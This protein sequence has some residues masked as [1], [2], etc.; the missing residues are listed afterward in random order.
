MFP[1]LFQKQQTQY[2]QNHRDQNLQKP[3]AQHKRKQKP[4]AKSNEQKPCLLCFHTHKKSPRSAYAGS[5]G[6]VNR[7]AGQRSLCRKNQTWNGSDTTN[8]SRSAPGWLISTPVKSRTRGRKTMSG[9]YSSP[10]RQ[11]ARK[12]AA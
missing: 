7:K 3:A 12:V 5:G 11:L 9:T 1:S 8:V 10:L 6:A 4:C 2:D